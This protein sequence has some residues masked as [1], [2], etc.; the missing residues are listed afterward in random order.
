[1]DLKTEVSEL[2]GIGP[3]KARAFRDAG[4]VTL[5][6]LMEFFPRRY[7][8]RR[9]VTP[10][11]S[12]RAGAECLVVAKVAAKR[13]PRGYYR[14]NSPLT[15][16]VSD[17]TGSLEIVFFNGRFLSGLFDEKSEYAFF[18]KV[19]E[20]HAM[21]QMIHPQFAK[22]G[23]AD[24]V[25]GIV[26]I[27]PQIPGIS[28]REIRRL[29]AELVPL[30]SE[31]EEW[32]PEKT[33]RE[34]RLASPEYAIKNTHFP[35]DGHRM[36]AGKFRL[37][38]GELF[39]METGLMYL[40]AGD[41]TG[42]KGVS[43]SCEAGDRFAAG[44]PFELTK[45]QQAAWKSIR[46]DLESDKRMNRLLQGDV[47]SGKTVIAE[48]AMLSAA[49][50]GL[51]SV[52]MAPTELL[53]TQHFDSFTKDLSGWK[54]PDGRPVSIA[55]LKSSLT[56]KEKRT[57]YGSLESGETDIL[58]C[59]H[60]V[61]EEKVKFRDLG[62]VITDEQHRFG[63][64]QRRILSEKGEN[65]NILVMTATPIPRT[66]AVIVYG[67]LDVSQIREMPAGRKPVKT[68]LARSEDRDKVYDFVEGQLIKGRQA[69]IVAPL[70]EESEKI[71]A[72]S[73]EEIFRLVSKRFPS[74]RVEMVHGAMR[75][76]EKDAI[77]Q[78][79]A[80]GE[81]DILVSTVVIE[82]GINVP[83]ASVMVI[84]NT[85]RFGLA[86]LHQLRGRVGRGTD[87]SYCFLILDQ[88]SEVAVKRAEIMCR[89]TDGFEIAEEDLALRGPGEL[90]G[91]R[92]HGLPQLMISDLSRH[93]D[94]LEKAAASAKELLADDPGLK[95][96]EN[97]P[98]KERIR[99]MFGENISLDL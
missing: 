60:A 63:V 2:K 18:G 45:G 19:S 21:R 61:L 83:N 76:Q 73:A 94:I 1:M 35:E 24:D 16:I 72:S 12:A 5:S 99:S 13:S 84:E 55:L 7:E 37:V 69:Y 44:L 51:Q 88:E 56:A 87:E 74:Y 30:Y 66:L 39:T 54:K 10:I 78:R 79:F 41:E 23:S 80:S 95:K 43:F 93:R 71:D 48:M 33:V 62:L 29:Q 15:L 82:V 96:P 75:P 52:M 17:G 22:A 89:T 3:K 31:L 34:Q 81:T 9:T 67:D 14:K 49:S 28:Q 65:V 92:Q 25:R 68:T 26:P 11:S 91:T 90:F 58:L 20:N 27:Y 36:L 64:R 77:M 86:Q 53:A 32:I 8:D 6:D 57:V 50:C 98:L 4:I 47:G 46:E 40:R 85:E 97:L 38:F 42:G 59:T 70:I